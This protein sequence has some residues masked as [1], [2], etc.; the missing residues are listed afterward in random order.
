M[1]AHQELSQLAVTV[2]NGIE[3]AVVLGECL[4]WAVGRGRELDA[5]HAHQLVKLATEH[6][7][8]G[9]VATALDDPVV[10]VVVAFLLVIALPG[11]KRGITLVGIEHTAQFV[12]VDLAHALGSQAAGHAFERLADLIQLDQFA[13]VER[14]HPRTYMG[15]PHQQALAFQPVDGLA[16]RASADAIGARQLRLGDLAA[17]GDITLDD[18]GLNAPEDV[19]GQGFRFVCRGGAG[20]AEV[21][22]IVD[23]LIIS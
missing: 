13:M 11:L 14:Y 12:D 5:V 1:A 2:G 3:Y 15:Y 17:R 21:Q 9:L 6:L 16:Q 20:G 18:G 23:T 8:Q 22:H 10:E 4:A 19:F 7:D